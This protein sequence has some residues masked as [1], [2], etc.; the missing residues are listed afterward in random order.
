M[1]G[2][3]AIGGIHLVGFFIAAR[4]VGGRAYRIA[5]RPIKARGIFCRIGHNL[6]I[7]EALVFERFT[8][9]ANATIHHIGGSND[10]CACLGMRYSLFYHDLNTDIIQHIMGICIDNTVLAMGGKWIQG[11][12]SYNTE[13][14]HSRLDSLDCPLGQAVRVVGF[15]GE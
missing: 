13:F 14:W 5:K 7:G 8:N 9:S 1:N 15:F 2:F 6:C 3:V 12:I 11:Y 4:K 10:I